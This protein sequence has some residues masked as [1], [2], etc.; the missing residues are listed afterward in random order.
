MAEA[1]IRSERHGDGFGGPGGHSVNL[2]DV[3]FAVL[4]APLHPLP[5]PSPFFNLVLFSSFKL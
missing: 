3:I 4:M 1:R 5:P 2:E